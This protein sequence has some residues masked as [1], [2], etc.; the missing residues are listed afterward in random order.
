MTLSTALTALR[1]AQTGIDVTSHNIANANTA[2]FTRQRVSLT[3]NTPYDSAVGPM[4]TGV[5]VEEIARIRDTF[6]DMRLHASNSALGSMEVK[7]DLLARTEALLGEPDFGITKEL[8]EVWATF[9]ELSLRPT[10]KSVRLTV[11]S[12]LDTLASRTRTIATSLDALGDD[13]RLQLNDSVNKAN[14]QIQQLADLNKMI[15][16][17]QG[18]GG[19]APNDLL[20][21]RD[22]LVDQLSR[23]LGAS[24]SYAEDGSTRLN[25]NGFELV[26]GQRANLLV[27]QPDNS[28]LHPSGSTV[29]GGGRIGGLQAFLV[30]PGGLLEG[31]KQQLNDFV[32]ELVTQVN[33][34]HAAGVDL[35]GAAPAA[36]PAPQ[37]L[38]LTGGADTLAVGIT[39][40]D[41][42]AA[43]SPGMGQ[44]DGSN[45]MALAQLRTKPAAVGLP[46]ID[47]AARGLITDLGA[48]VASARRQAAAEG[49]LNSAAAS[50]R[51]DHNAV[52]L[53]EEMV[54]LV[55]YQRSYE[56]AARVATT[57]DE[58]LQ[59]VVS[60]LGVVGR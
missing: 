10:D 15:A 32:T 36:P 20:D 42:L 30:T 29:P 24:A 13:V 41:L 55:T 22:L 38:E 5:G 2:G 54:G 14:D 44:L 21:R 49:G 43:A 33:M 48:Q 35:N 4:G 27:L 7:A 34:Q 58:M 23:S 51:R 3:T 45:A 1:A 12:A 25:L 46:V 28:L 59:T 18:N 40:P 56:A 19:G 47:E 50:A 39:D 17:L 16:S 53:D 52:S 9:D 31:V 8:G 60:R 57:I 11:L 6:L 37:L 26:S